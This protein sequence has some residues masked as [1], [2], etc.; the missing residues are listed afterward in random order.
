MCHVSRASAPHTTHTTSSPDPLSVCPVLLHSIQAL[1]HYRD[2]FGVTFKIRADRARTDLVAEAAEAERKA[3]AEAEVEAAG[4]ADSKEADGD[5]GEDGTEA[6]PD[7][8]ED[9]GTRRS[10][11]KE[12]RRAEKEARKKKE[13]EKKNVDVSA[14][15][16]KSAYTVVL[17]CLGVGFKNYARKTA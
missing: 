10:T 9:K 12:K 5:E 16:A 4:A 1:R 8:A 3:K 13:A 17:S 2:I 14:V 11:K 15:A 7:A 6:E